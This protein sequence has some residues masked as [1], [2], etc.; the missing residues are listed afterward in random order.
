LLNCGHKYNYLA[1]NFTKKN[2]LQRYYFYFL[3]C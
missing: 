3:I 2:G 1:L